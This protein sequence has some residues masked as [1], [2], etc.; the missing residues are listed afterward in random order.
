MEHLNAPVVGY[1]RRA[2]SVVLDQHDITILPERVQAIVLSDGGISL[3]YETVDTMITASFAGDERNA[4][5]RL[6][7]VRTRGWSKTDVGTV[8]TFRGARED[9]TPILT[10]A[11]L[12]NLTQTR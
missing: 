12:F 11:N 5:L 7:Q 8:D 3:T 6:G 10:A 4:T 1:A 9:G 2:L